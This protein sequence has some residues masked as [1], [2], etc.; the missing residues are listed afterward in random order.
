MKASTIR[1][2]EESRID[3]PIAIVA[4]LEIE[5]S[6]ASAIRAAIPTCAVRKT[7][8]RSLG[9]AFLPSSG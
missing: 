7:P 8:R 6:S 2:Q 3:E 9:H 1:D 5:V 4:A